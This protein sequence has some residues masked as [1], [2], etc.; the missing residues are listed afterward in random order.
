MYT[1]LNGYLKH[2]HFWNIIYIHVCDS[3]FFSLAVV[4]A[5]LE[6]AVVAVHQHSAIHRIRYGI[7]FHLIGC[8]A[9]C[10]LQMFLAHLPID[11]LCDGSIIG[12]LSDALEIAHEHRSIRPMRKRVAKLEKQHALAH[13]LPMPFLRIWRFLMHKF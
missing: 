13:L 5:A 10:L 8:V 9:P 4:A 1:A 3:V 12:V 6:V 7:Y 2:I 11:C